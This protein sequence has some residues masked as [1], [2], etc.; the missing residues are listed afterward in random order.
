MEQSLDPTEQWTIKRLTYWYLDRGRYRQ[1]EALARGLL[2]LDG[3]DATAWQY[4]AEAR[5]QQDD[6]AEAAR[7]F[8]EAA[9]IY[10]HRADIW[11]RL[12]DMLLRL[13]RPNDA[14]RALDEAKARTTDEA[15]VQRI[16]ALSARCRL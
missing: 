15:L 4:Y 5:F 13:D 14:R 12:G 8:E 10:E 7:G 16:E 11:M 3:G 1:A 9:R 2:T 6:L